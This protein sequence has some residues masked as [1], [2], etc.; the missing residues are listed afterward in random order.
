L[1]AS[2]E[3]VE[4]SA[5]LKK[6]SRNPALDLTAIRNTGEK[7]AQIDRNIACV[8]EN[9]REL[10]PVVWDF[11]L[12]KEALPEG[13]LNIIAEKTEGLYRRLNMAVL[14]FK[15]YLITQYSDSIE[16]VS[17]PLVKTEKSAARVLT[18]DAPYFVTGEIIRGLKKAGAEVDIFGLD[19]SYKNN[20]QAGAI[21]I[22]KLVD[23]LRKNRSDFLLTVNHLGFDAEGF[24]LKE[25]ER[26]E[27]K[28]AVYY[29]DSPLFILDEPEKLVSDL[30]VIFS[31]DD[32]YLGRLKAYGFRNLIYLPLG[33]DETVFRPRDKGQIPLEYQPEIGYAA[34]SLNLRAAE[35]SGY[36]TA[37]MNSAAAAEKIS[38]AVSVNGKAIPE[39]LEEA[40]KDFKFSSAAQRRHFLAA[41]IMKVHQPQRLEVLQK[42]TPLGLKIFGDDEWK[43]HFPNGR[44]ELSGR[45]KYYEQLPLLYAGTKIGFDSTSPQ[46]PRGVNQRVFDIPAAGGFLLTDYR[47]ALT[48]IFD[49]EKDI[50]VY[51]T[52]EEA[53]D[54]AEFY[55]M[56]PELREKMALKARAKILAGHTYKHRAEFIIRK[57]SHP[58]NIDS[59]FLTEAKP[60]A[61]K[62]TAQ[63]S[64]FPTDSLTEAFPET[65]DIPRELCRHIYTDKHLTIAPERAAWV[66]TD[67]TGA[68]IIDRL[69]SGDSIGRTAAFLA[70]EYGYSSAEA[71]LKVK[72]LIELCN[73]QNFRESF[74]TARLDIDKRARNLQLFLTRRCNLNCRHCYFSAGEPMENELTTEQ[75]KSVIRKFARLGAGS[76]VT[77]TG[78]EPMMRKDFWEIAQEAVDQG[79]KLALL[80]NGGLIR[81]AVIA[82][83]IADM[84]DIVQISLDGTTA[85]IND[86]VRGKGSFDNAVRAIRLLLAEKVEVEMTM[87]VLPENVQD[88]ERNL[89]AFVQYLGGGKLRCALAVANP[90]GRLKGNLN[91]DAVSL[92]GRVLTA[93]GAQKWMR[94]GKFQPGCTIFGC[95]LATS[96]VVNPDGK[97]GNCPYLNYSGPR[98]ALEADFARLVSEDCA[99]HRGAMEKSAKCKVCDLRNFQCGGCQI[100][101]KCGEQTKARNYY[102]MLE[103][104]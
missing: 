44:P 21:F 75:W 26:L 81:D 63:R 94:Q 55:L 96:I 89:A 98:S 47:E 103:E 41:W 50:A 54:K 13:E 38:A 51:R 90:K 66:V 32:Y 43:I 18:I 102:R 29:V 58:F 42:L 73:K 46:M 45:L 60:A 25:L 35:H 68:E 86:A 56:R 97:I 59:D 87:V 5:V 79:L 10:R 91:T 69:H 104:K 65:I 37:E 84:F 88:L 80:S 23:Q 70:D 62:S 72:E 39:I 15:K 36:L 6:L 67:K 76:L 61:G 74:D 22:E 49:P 95:E 53:Y 93:V 34:D 24:L 1:E 85:E 4:Q 77:L 31:W 30:S 57:M 11:N 33:T 17:T 48:D 20:P 99:W 9:C 16:P 52:A 92:A 82:G 19:N 14:L 83:R 7:I 12:G 101:G 64:G 27:I 71:L 40:A 100:F 2:L 8:G 3:G 28:S 78:G